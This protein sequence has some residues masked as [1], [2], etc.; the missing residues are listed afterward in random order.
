M[1]FNGGR[2]HKSRPQKRE[3]GIEMN[4]DP[5]QIAVR[6][7][8]GSGAIVLALSG[9]VTPEDLPDLVSHVRGLLETSAV[10]RIVC[11]V[12]ALADPDLATVDAL[13]R[14]QLAAR[15]RGRRVT[16]VGASTRLGELLDICGL[17]EAIPPCR[18]L[19]V[20]ARR[21]PEQW[22]QRGSVEEEHDPG[23]PVV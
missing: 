23:D 8:P 11:D 4:P 16:L 20:D 13:A 19:I 6:A 22:K 15:R 9:T 5:P 12:E 14:L 1:S 3:G 18:G 17:D 10:E 2:S 21:E 7:S